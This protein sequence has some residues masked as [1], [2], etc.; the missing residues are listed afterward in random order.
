MTYDKS[1][2]SPYNRGQLDFYYWRQ[3]DPHYYFNFNR[4]TKR[5]SVHLMSDNQIDAYKAGYEKAR[6]EGDRKQFDSEVDE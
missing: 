3:P 2:G 1:H 5:M 6:K 4:Q